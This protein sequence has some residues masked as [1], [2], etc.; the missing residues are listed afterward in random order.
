MLN[1]VWRELK[2]IREELPVYMCMESSAAWRTVSGG[3]PL[4]GSELVEV[5]SRRGRLPIL[6]S[7][8]E[9]HRG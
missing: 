8:S 6:Q 9:A 1:F 2:A 7:T 5:F 3:N 4:A